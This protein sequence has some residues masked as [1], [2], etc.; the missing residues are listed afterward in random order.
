[1]TWGSITHELEAMFPH[2]ILRIHLVEVRQLKHG[3]VLRFCTHYVRV[4]ATYRSPNHWR[5]LTEELLDRDWH[6][7]LPEGCEQSEKC[8]TG[9]RDW[10]NKK[11]AAT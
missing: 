11:E 2:R 6:A 7:F 8:Q 1:M 3:F 9:C 4:T 10:D 5:E